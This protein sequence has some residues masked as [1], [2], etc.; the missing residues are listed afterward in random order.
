MLKNFTF[1][2]LVLIGFI[3][4]GCKKINPPE[5]I[6]SYLFIPYAT[7]ATDSVNQG[8]ML[9][10]FTDVWVFKGD[11][12]IGCYPTGSR[13]PVLAE[14]NTV[15]KMR[16]GIKN[17]GVASLRSIYTLTQFYETTINLKRGQ[18]DTLIPVFEYFSGISFLRMESFSNPGTIFT[19]TPSSDTFLVNYPGTGSEALDGQGNCGFVYLD[20]TYQVFEVQTGSSIPYQIQGRVCYL[21]IQCKT[22]SDLFVSVSDGANDVRLCGTIYDTEGR[23]KKIYIPLTDNL[24]TFPTLYNFYLILRATRLADK[25][26]PRIYIDNIKVI[27][28]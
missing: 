4:A 22:N 11:E 20:Q 5:E 28:Q 24:N 19:P 21:E 13:V 6:P 3:L 12:F 17:A 10:D 18:I 7:F 15:I 9:H 1:F 25:P 26:D 16:A 2:F 14:G 27:R 23:W 8:T